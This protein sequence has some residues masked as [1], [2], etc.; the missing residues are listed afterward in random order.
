M[1]MFQDLPE[2]AIRLEHFQKGKEEITFINS[3]T[4][5]NRF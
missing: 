5:I 4:G 1:R 2:K 3:L